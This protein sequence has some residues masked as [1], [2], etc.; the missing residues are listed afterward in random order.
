MKYFFHLWNIFFILWNIFFM[1]VENLLKR[2]WKLLKSMWYHFGIITKNFCVYYKNFCVT[3]ITIVRYLTIRYLTKK[4]FLSDTTRICAFQKI[5][6]A[7]KMFNFL[8]N[9]FT[10]KSAEINCGSDLRLA[11]WLLKTPVLTC[12]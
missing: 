1:S 6:L 2:C 12:G 4:I 10:K 11:I 3:A 9:L 5:F 7:S 8:F